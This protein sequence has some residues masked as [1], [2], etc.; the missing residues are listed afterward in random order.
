MNTTQAHYSFCQP[1]DVFQNAC[2]DRATVSDILSDGIYELLIK[3]VDGSMSEVKWVLGQFGAFMMRE[4]EPAEVAPITFGDLLHKDWVSPSHHFTWELWEN[5][6]HMYQSLAFAY[7]EASFSCDRYAKCADVAYQQAR[8][9]RDSKPYINVMEQPKTSAIQHGF[10][11][12]DKIITSDRISMKELDPSCDLDIVLTRIGELGNV[13]SIND[14]HIKVRF[15]KMGVQSDIPHA[16]AVAKLVIRKETVKPS[17]T[18]KQVRQPKD[19]TFKA[20]DVVRYSGQPGYYTVRTLEGRQ[21][22][23]ETHLQDNHTL[24]GT[25][26]NL[27]HAAMSD[28]L[29]PIWQLKFLTQLD[30]GKA[31]VKKAA[32]RQALLR[33]E[34]ITTGDWDAI[35]LTVS[36][37]AW[38][39]D[40]LHREPR[41]TEPE[42]TPETFNVTDVTVSVR[43]AYLD[44]LWMKG[45]ITFKGRRVVKIESTQSDNWAQLRFPGGS[46]KGGEWVEWDDRLAIEGA[47]EPVEDVRLD[48]PA[49]TQLKLW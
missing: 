43:T 47:I 21:V 25:V 15:P 34:F 38:L 16:V 44:R 36:G 39:D 30:T 10:K 42:T 46:T 4:P 14:T 20:G 40:W 24:Q 8:M 2:G 19:N 45:P 27:A 7:P 29:L 33:H 3:R 49:Q 26:D 1:G 35:A 48:T 6:A 13:E 22:S 12:G 31:V 5:E 9:K 32:T 18:P 23:L 11:A 41:I 28:I 37:R 17:P